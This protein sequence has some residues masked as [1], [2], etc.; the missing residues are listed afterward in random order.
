MDKQTANYYFSLVKG[1]IAENIA[2]EMF[3]RLKFNIERFGMENQATGIAKLL[4]KYENTASIKKLRQM[5]D[6]V[7]EKSGCGVSFLEV[8]YRAGGII[9]VA[10]LLAYKQEYPDIVFL[11]FT[12]Y[13]LH[14]VR[15]TD[16]DLSG[17]VPAKFYVAPDRS[18][19]DDPVFKFT[20]KEKLEIRH[21]TNLAKV[22]IK[23]I[24]LQDDVTKEILTNQ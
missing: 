9:K 7:I 4:R 18:F 13:G 17:D 12:K 19:A 16:D 1:R 15:F 3:G 11:I 21:F 2:E 5:P 23:C 20:A 24:D 14:S 10:D 8:K 22:F 6:F